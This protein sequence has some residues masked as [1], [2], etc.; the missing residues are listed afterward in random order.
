MLLKRKF[1]DGVLD[2]VE[3]KQSSIEQNFTQEFIN[4][5]VSSGLMSFSK[6][7]IIL[8]T[9]P[10]LIY[11]V[12]RTPGFYCCHD[13]EKLSSE[14]D[15]KTYTNNKFNGIKSPDDNNPVGYRKDNFFHCVQES[16]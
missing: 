8:H 7:K 15:A 12:V 10:E 5:S 2:Y 13:N 3:V 9:K 1:K 4:D 11:A 6:G 14:L 16:K